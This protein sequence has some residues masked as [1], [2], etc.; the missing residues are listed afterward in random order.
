MYR[1]SGRYEAKVDVKGRIF[2]P[3]AY[4]RMLES[5][6]ETSM[7][8]RIDTDNKYKCKYVKLYPASEWEKIDAE[9]VSKLNMWNKDDQRLYRQF[10]SSVEQLELDSNGRVLIQKKYLDIVGIEAEALFV[11]VGSCFEIWKKEVHEETCLP[12]EDFAAALE[13]KMGGLVF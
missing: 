11:G 6:G 5:A 10:M 3:A 9:L 13:E 1:F 12:D 2:V 8:L 4:R 7:Y